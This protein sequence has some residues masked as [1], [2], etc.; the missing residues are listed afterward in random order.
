MKTFNLLIAMVVASSA[1]LVAQSMAQ[2]QAPPSTRQQSPTP[3]GEAPALGSEK[4]VQGQVQ[5]IDPSEREITLTDGTTLVLPP[6]A[7]LKPGALRAGTTVIAS[8]REEQGKNVLTALALA[9]PSAPPEPRQPGSSSPP[10]PGD[11]PKRY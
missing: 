7:A 6:G 4:T 3:R 2:T 10:G 8:Y 5:S 11:S 1:A 9:D